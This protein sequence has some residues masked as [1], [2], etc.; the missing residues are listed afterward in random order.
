M[1]RLE[2]LRNAGYTSVQ[3]ADQLNDDGFHPP[4]CNSFDAMTIRRLLSR[5]RESHAPERT[6][7]PQWLLRDLAEK[8]GMPTRTLRSWLDRGW[9]HGEQLGGAHGRWILWV[10]DDELN[11][12]TQLRQ[13]REKS[14][15]LPTPV[16]LTNPKPRPDN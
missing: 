1:V 10:D 16:E 13:H 5:D 9:L 14:T 2:D 6:E 4:N 7:P 8:L 15:G 12:L 3:I 11:R